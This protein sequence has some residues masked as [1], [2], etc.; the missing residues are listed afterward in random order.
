MF[1]G[2]ELGAYSRS[3]ADLLNLYLGIGLTMSELFLFIFLGLIFQNVNF[4]ALALLDNGS[5]YACAF[6][7][8]HSSLKAAVCGY[9]EHTVK[10]Y[11]FT[12][13]CLKLFYKE[14]IALLNLVLL[15]ARFDYCK[16]EKHLTFVYDSLMQAAAVCD[17]PHFSSLTLSGRLLYHDLVRM[18]T[19]CV[20]ENAFC[21]AEYVNFM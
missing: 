4:L 18:S 3:N 13:L 17:G 12:G 16:H 1:S 20:F 2:P 10:R 15:S 6:H 14:D 8:R 11:L 7:S 19:A 21:R 5:R 9:R